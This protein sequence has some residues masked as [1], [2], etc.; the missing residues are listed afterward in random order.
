MIDLSTRYLGLELKNPIVASPSPLCEQVDNIKRMEDVGIGAVVLHSLFEEQLVREDA[1]FD[2]FLGA[3]DETH[4]EALSYFP[5]V[6]AYRSSSD[7]YLETLSRAC[8][9][10]DIPVLGSLNGVSAEG[11]TGYA[12]GMEQAGAAAIEL[13]VYH[14]PADITETGTAVEDRYLAAVHAVPVSVMSAGMW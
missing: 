13:N 12:T 8:D 5:P 1:A 11:W 4:V 9:R 6:N 3:A 2:H 7:R 10:C 14:I